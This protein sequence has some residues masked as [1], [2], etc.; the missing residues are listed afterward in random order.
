MV[1]AGAIRQGLATPA[2][3]VL[4]IGGLYVGQS[5]ISG[6]MFSALPIVLRERGLPLDAIGLTYLAILPWALRFLWAPAVERYR[7]PAGGVTR[8]RAIV[9]GGM[10]VAVAGLAVSGF[11]GPAALGTLIAVFVAVAC[12]ASTVDIACDGHAVETLARRH[13]G[14][15]NAAQVAGAYLGAAIGSGFFLLLVA[16][17]GW[18]DA[19]LVT[20]GLV[21]VLALPFVLAPQPRSPRPPDHVP[22]L[23]EA[24]RRREMRRGLVLAAVFVVAQKWAL[25]MLGPYLVDAGV[26]LASLGLLNGAGGLA[27]GFVCALI[28]GALVRA[29]GARPILVTGLA[30]QSATLALVAATA[31]LGSAPEALLLALALA[32]S[33]AVIAVSFVALYA[34]FM[35][36]CD[37]RQAGIDFSLL[38]CTDAAVS[39]VG[40]ILAGWVAERAGYGIWFA[41]AAAFAAAAAPLALILSRPATDPVAA[42]ILTAP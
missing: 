6:L 1:S 3:I 15:G 4:A 16:R 9:A 13:H 32:S 24:L 25:A 7:L 35:E 36:L 26:S 17:L 27:V 38:Q 5:V 34:G 8:S 28:G 22:S 33:S 2:G 11:V 10:L 31:F 37:P 23:R 19:V 14:Y 39:M 12:A 21:L 30:L 29:F 41:L 40:G 20:S 42:P 18:R